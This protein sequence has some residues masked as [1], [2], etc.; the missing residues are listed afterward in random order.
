[1]K[2]LFFTADTHFHHANIIEYSNRPFDSVEEMDETLVA[3]WNAV[4]PKDGVVYHLGDFGWK[5]CGD[6]LPR[7][8]GSI[9]LIRGSHDQRVRRFEQHFAGILEG[10]QTLSIPM[11]KH[12]VVM[13]HYAMLRWPKSHFGTWHL[14][15]HSHGS[16]T[17]EA[18]AID[19]GVDCHG[20]TPLSWNRIV[21]IM[22]SKPENPNKVRR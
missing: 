9:Y 21:E 10:Y 13:C 1:M 22:E 19:V 6:I 11:S 2:P 15:G 5:N 3:N 14:F 18:K 7:L 16:L 8:N 20:F 4:V 17:M 12:I